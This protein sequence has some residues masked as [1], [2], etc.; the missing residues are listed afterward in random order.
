MNNSQQ[1]FKT[2][3]AANTRTYVVLLRVCVFFH[4]HNYIYYIS[5]TLL[6]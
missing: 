3:N 1:L 6:S 2:N 5:E 4:K